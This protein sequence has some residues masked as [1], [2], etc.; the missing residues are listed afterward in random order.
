MIYPTPSIF[1]CPLMSKVS[2]VPD[3]SSAKERNL[4]YV[5]DFHRKTG[6]RSKIVIHQ[7]MTS[8][9]GLNKQ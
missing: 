1:D 7:I 4:Y 2:Y 5:D 9:D 3:V 8:S 6:G